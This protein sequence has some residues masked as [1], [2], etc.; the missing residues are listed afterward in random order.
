MLWG[1]C[2]KIAQ[3]LMAIACCV[4]AAVYLALSSGL[5]LISRGWGG[6][7]PA[8]LLFQRLFPEAPE[9]RRG[10][11]KKK[12]GGVEGGKWRGTQT[13]SGCNFLRKLSEPFFVRP[14][15]WNEGERKRK[16][17]REMERK[18]VR[19]RQGGQKGHQRNLPSQVHM[20][21]RKG[22]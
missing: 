15:R 5:S 22:S 14:I 1:T 2:P 8:P 16:R 7:L 3:Q 19:V 11:R 20:G 18:T 4:C 13:G 21:P 9:Q 10:R 17:G 6:F 12:A